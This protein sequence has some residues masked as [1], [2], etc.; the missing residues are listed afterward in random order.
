MNSS[1][2]KLDLVYKFVNSNSSKAYLFSRPEIWVC[3]YSP[4]SDYFAW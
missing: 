3:T 4:H 2:E 1:N